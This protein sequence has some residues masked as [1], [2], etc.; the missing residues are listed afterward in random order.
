VEYVN[1]K[2]LGFPTTSQFNGGK[3][4]GFMVEGSVAF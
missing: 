4:S 3:F 2:Y 1:Q